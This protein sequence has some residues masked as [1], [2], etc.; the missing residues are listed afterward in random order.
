MN[1]GVSIR[2]G[3]QDIIGIGAPQRMT[4][5]WGGFLQCMSGLCATISCYPSQW[6][7]SVSEQKDISGLGSSS[8]CL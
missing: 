2:L 3:L 1:I 8:P 6:Q 7:T 4:T 5:N